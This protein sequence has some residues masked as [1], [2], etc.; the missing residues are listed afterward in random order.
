MI[1]IKSYPHYFLKILCYNYINTLDLTTMNTTE[2]TIGN[3]EKFYEDIK[4]IS[5]KERNEQAK[6]NLKFSNTIM[7]K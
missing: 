6:L 5:E 2:T 7:I 1:K 3:Y 4:K